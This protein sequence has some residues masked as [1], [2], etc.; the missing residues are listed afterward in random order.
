MLT[1]VQPYE[2]GTTIT[3]ILQMSN[4]R[5]R[6]VKHLAQGHTASKG[7]R[8]KTTWHVRGT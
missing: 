5:H 3:L 8:H 4:L 2:L 7:W 1:P 6:A